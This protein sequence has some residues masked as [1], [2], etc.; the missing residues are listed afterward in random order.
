ML[1]RRAYAVA[2]AVAGRAAL[3]LRPSYSPAVRGPSG[4]APTP[5]APQQLSPTCCGLRVQRAVPARADTS[6]PTNSPTVVSHVQQ[7]RP[8]AAAASLLGEHELPYAYTTLMAART[9]RFDTRARRQM[10]A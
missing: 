2:S 10:A 3:A 6:L 8:A 7:A 4:S 1:A 9:V 5:L